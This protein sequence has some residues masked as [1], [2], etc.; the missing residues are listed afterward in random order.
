MLRRRDHQP[1]S[2]SQGRRNRGRA[3]RRIELQARK[4]DQILV[5]SVDRR[6]RRHPERPQQRFASAARGDLRQR[7]APGAA[8]DHCQPVDA[9][10]FTPAP[11][12]PL[13]LPDRAASAPAP[14]GRAGRPGRRR[15]ARRR[16]SAIIAALSVHSQP[17]GTEK[18]RPCSAASCFSADRTARV[19]G[20]T[21]GDHQCRR[22]GSSQRPPGSVGEA[23]DHRLLEAGGDVLPAGARRARR[24]AARRLLRPAK[25][26]MRHARAEQGTR[27]RHRL[28]SPRSPA[29]DRRPPGKPGRAAWPPCRRLRRPHRRWSSP[30]GDSR[31]P[32][33]PRAAGN[34][35]RETSSSR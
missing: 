13:R 9:H 4:I 31:R 19:G 2:A 18:R 17:G 30:A 33:A 7:S 22:V 6:R 35:R 24:R 29:L 20:D 8:A 5:D 32:L 12:H 21:A 1:A 34:G 28:G 25:A 10:A 3:D 11:A 16:P 27:Q 15:S 26:E 23:V 14:G